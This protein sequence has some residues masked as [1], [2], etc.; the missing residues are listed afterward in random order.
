[1][2]GFQFGFNRWIAINTGTAF[3]FGTWGTADS[4]F[5]VTSGPWAPTIER[6]SDLDEY[7]GYEE[8][9]SSG[10]SRIIAMSIGGQIS[11][12]ATPHIIAVL[13]A[14]ALGS[15]SSAT[16]GTLGTLATAYRHRIRPLKVALGTLGAGNLPFLTVSE[17]LS[18]TSDFQFD[19]QS[20]AVT[21][22]SIST[23]RKDWIQ[24][25]AELLG[26]GVRRTSS[27]AKPAVLS[28]TYLKAGD[29]RIYFGT[30]IAAT[31]GTQ[32][33]ATSVDITGTA[34]GTTPDVTARVIDFNWSINNNLAAD[35]GYG[36]DSGT[37]RDHLD[38]GPRTQSLKITLELNNS[39]QWTMLESAK[40]LALELECY[41]TL[42]ES[43][44]YYGFNLGF[45]K[46][47]VKT[48]AVAGGPRDKMTI[49]YDFD[50]LEDTTKGSVMLDVYNTRVAYAI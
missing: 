32:S 26:N 46:L 38:R 35:D 47:S 20:A 23:K 15:W 2:P 18:G 12:R 7:T 17:S 25:T 9:S 49:A 4:A 42:I 43:N 30:A 6:K 10:T 14:A 48:A 36:M 31:L 27:V 5:N 13:G 16:A 29:V 45:P 22:F 33:K 44:A 19:Y 37:T 28:E 40:V 24:F 39:A 11:G 21:S 41:N 34:Y 8:D 3:G 50:V 1:M